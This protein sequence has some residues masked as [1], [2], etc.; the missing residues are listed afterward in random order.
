MC[1][2]L[3]CFL[4]ASAILLPSA[5]TPMPSSAAGP[6]VK[7]RVSHVRPDGTVTVRLLA[8][9]VGQFTSLSA[10]LRLGET[11]LTALRCPQ[12]AGRIRKT[13]ICSEP[14]PGL[15]RLGVVGFNS[16]ALIDG[17]V[18]RVILSVPTDVRPGQ[19]SISGVLHFARDDGSEFAIGPISDTVRIRRRVRR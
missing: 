5:L 19:Y 1:K 2:T 14:E 18:A 8:R 9:H 6:I 11:G 13:V 17:E 12:P 16:D 3:Q 10:D 7:L 15:V 4:V